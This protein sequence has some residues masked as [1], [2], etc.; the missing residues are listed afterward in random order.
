[1]TDTKQEDV[2]EPKVYPGT[3]YDYT[4]GVY[5]GVLVTEPVM[6]KLAK[7]QQQHVEA[8]RRVLHDNREGVYPSGWT[9]HHPDGEQ[10]V[11]RFIE[12][13]ADVDQRIGW[14]TSMREP[15]AAHPV[16]VAASKDEA[17]AMADAHT[18]ERRKADD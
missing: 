3:L 13:A 18:P 15:E 6:R 4:A 14:A 9:L 10:T 12:T 5:C 11:V 2:L 7:L 8:V 1:M 16:F 17:K